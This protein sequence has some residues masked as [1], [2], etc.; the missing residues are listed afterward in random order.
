MGWC[1][2][3]GFAGAAG[4]GAVA[5][6][7]GGGDDAA[8]AAP[9]RDSLGLVWRTAALHSLGCWWLRLTGEWRC[10]C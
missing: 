4:A 7:G 6:A 3:A 5:A 2:N 9:D 8:E 10:W 1:E